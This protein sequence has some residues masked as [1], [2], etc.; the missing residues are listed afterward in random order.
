MLKKADLKLLALHPKNLKTK[1]FYIVAPLKIKVSGKFKGVVTFMSELIEHKIMFNYKDFNL[2][3][4][5]DKAKQTSLMF[6]VNLNIYL[7]KR[8][9]DGK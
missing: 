4:L 5:S 1:N 9:N 8:I 3:K 6:D 2:Y 7:K